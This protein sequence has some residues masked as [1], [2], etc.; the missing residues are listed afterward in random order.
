MAD[1]RLRTLVALYGVEDLLSRGILLVDDDPSNIEVLR[2][3]LDQDYV[4][5]LATS[6]TEALH[7]AARVDL[8]V[9]ITDQR[10][11]EMTGV[12]LLEKLRDSKPDVAGVL[13]TAYTDTP[14]LMNAI[15][16]ARAFRFLKKPWEPSE[17]QQVVA[18]ASDHVFQ[19][20]AIERLLDLLSRRTTELAHRSDELAGTIDELRGA[21]EKMLHLERLGTTGRLAAGLAHDLRNVMVPFVYLESELERAGLADPVLESVQV[22]M[23]GFRNLLETLET[24]RGFAR[25]SRMEVKMETIEPGAVIR[26]AVAIA[27][28]DLAYRERRVS[29]RVRDGLPQIDG[30]RYKLTQVLINLIRNAVQATAPG[31]AVIIEAAPG[32]PGEVLFAVE[33]EGPGVPGN[34][35]ERLFAPFVTSR[36]ESGTGMG[37]YMARLIVEEH[38]GTI[39]CFDRAGGGTR[40]EVKLASSPAAPAHPH[41]PA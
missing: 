15:N 31:Q 29:V 10:M 23:A 27:R 6:G 16:R 22:G 11:P 21:Q 36:G 4:V 32:F 17:V 33:D 28:M 24:L 8:D 12:E 3:F 39:S 26:D 37:L 20:R 41:F 40:F 9:V 18:Q 35:R 2:E 38:R 30:D 5:H 19:R 13:L 25:G 34:M 14:A 1:E 7:I